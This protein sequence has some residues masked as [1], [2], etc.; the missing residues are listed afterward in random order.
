MF[1]FK[2]NIDAR[3]VAQRYIQSCSTLDHIKTMEKYL[4][5]YKD[6]FDD[7]LGHHSLMLELDNKHELIKK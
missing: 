4:E 3:L 7:F 6:K 1:D 5:F 2:L